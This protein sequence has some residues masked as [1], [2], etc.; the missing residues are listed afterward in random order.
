MRSAIH[1]RRRAGSRRRCGR[2]ALD[3][4][5]PAPR[6]HPRKICCRRWWL[7]PALAW[8][9]LRACV[10][11]WE[12]EEVGRA[13]RIVSALRYDAKGDGGVSARDVEALRS[14]SFT[15]QQL[16]TGYVNLYIERYSW[17]L[18]VSA[19]R[20]AAARER[21]ALASQSSLVI[22]IIVSLKSVDAAKREIPRRAT[23]RACD[24]LCTECQDLLGKRLE[25]T[26]EDE[27]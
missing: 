10:R 15:P 18:Y 8:A 26:H 21:G 12:A 6:D 3:L 5:S 23:T 20:Q 17:L 19:S 1:H 13:A 27:W 2:C 22:A 4:I 14:L 11:F 24:M 16:V 9:L 7:L 25:Y